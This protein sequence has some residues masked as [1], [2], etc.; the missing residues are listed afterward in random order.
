MR[1]PVGSTT[2]FRVRNNIANHPTLV[3]EIEVLYMTDFAIGGT[4]YVAA[5]LFDALQ[6]KLFLSG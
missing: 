2:T 3:V 4:E 1:A 5:D 6:Y